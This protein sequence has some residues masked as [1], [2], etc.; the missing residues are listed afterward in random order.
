MRQAGRYLPEYRAL[1][2]IADGFLDL[3][4]NS[5]LAAD[6]LERFRLHRPL[7]RPMARAKPAILA[8]GGGCVTIWRKMRPDANASEERSN[9]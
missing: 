5:P 9:K 4:F 7:F 8:P 6:D 3:C 1:R 2:E